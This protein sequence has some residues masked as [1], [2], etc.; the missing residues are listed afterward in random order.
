MGT[1]HNDHPGAG[2]PARLLI[3]ED[4]ALVR[5]GL[6]AMLAGAEDLEVIGEAE[7]GRGAVEMCRSLSPDLVL[8]DVRMPEMDGLEAT[9]RIKEAQPR[10]GVLMVT[11]HQDPDYLLEA[12]RSGAAGYVLKEATKSRLLSAVRRVLS[13]EN[14]LDQELAMRLIARVS[15]EPGRGRERPLGRTGTGATEKVPEAL[16]GVLSAR[17]TEALRLIA[18]GK[19]NRQI[20][21]ELMVSLST[22]KTHVQRIIRKLGVSDRTQASVKAIELGL[23]AGDVV[24]EEMAT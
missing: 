15:E 3:A 24:D 20:A 22:V 6:R 18:S 7:N 2:K 11:T 1:E 12:V 17:E 4:H 10:V 21:K 5:E 8:M 9:R 14:A 16:V 23:L 13:G 19:T